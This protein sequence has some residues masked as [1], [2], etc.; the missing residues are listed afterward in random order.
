MTAARTAAIIG[1][2]ISPY[3]RKVLAVCALKGIEV[4]IDPLV[5]FYGDDRFTKLSP[6]R[7]IPVYRD[8][9]VTLCD[10]SVIC[11]YLEDAY[12]S[13]RLYPEDIAV[14][15]QARW[16]EEY[17]D[18][19]IGDV[20]AWRIFQAAVI[21]PGVWGRPRDKAALEAAVTTELP[22][23]MDYL[24]EQVPARGYIFGDLSI[25]EISIVPY[26]ANLNWARVEPDA[27]RWPKTV[28]WVARAR[29]EPAF[30]HYEKLAAPLVRTPIS[31]HRRVLGD[32]GMKLTA[33]TYFTATPRRGPMTVK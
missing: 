33:D 12:P 24:E 4:E 21:D 6:V 1:S 7:R 22:Q 18:T 23:I 2:P 26:F 8:A 15:A 9:R 11:Q 3:A 14:R 28:A 32:L 29:A 31:D 20:F 17:A 13:P 25:A 5:A 10:S 30:A 19:R 27:N 16:L